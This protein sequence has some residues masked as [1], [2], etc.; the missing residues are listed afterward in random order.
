MTSGRPITKADISKPLPLIS[1]HAGAQILSASQTSR[2]RL[3]GDLFNMHTTNGP[4][5][6]A[7]STEIMPYYISM[8]FCR[9]DSISSP[10][11]L[12]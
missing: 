11:L 6:D 5:I 10:L 4:A 8:L 7:V 9:K 2:P 12:V 1:A 3:N